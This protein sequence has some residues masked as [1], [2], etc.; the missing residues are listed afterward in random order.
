ML[1][2]MPPEGRQTIAFWLLPGF[3]AQ[4]C[5]ILAITALLFTLIGAGITATTYLE[6]SFLEALPQA[7]FSM[8]TAGLILQLTGLLAF[9]GGAL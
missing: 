7:G 6:Q 4:A 8:L 2:V 1:W 3:L 9:S 5:A